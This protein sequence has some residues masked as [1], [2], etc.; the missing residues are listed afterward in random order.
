MAK[1]AYS[2]FFGFLLGM[3]ILQGPLLAQ[4]KDTLSD[5]SLMANNKEEVSLKDF[6]SS[7]AVVIVFTSS[8]CK[9]AT[10]YEERLSELNETY[11]EK[12]ISFIAINSNDP[13]L[14]DS[15][16]ETQMAR[17]SHYSFPYLKD[18]DQSVAKQF[19][20]VKTPE[21]IVATPKDGGFHEAYRGK[22]DDN[23]LDASLAKNHYLE[24]ALKQILADEAVT[25]T[26]TDASGCNIKWIR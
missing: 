24:D 9:W 1:L 13:S 26:T 25:V 10:M 15:D 11:S 5:F 17:L 22:I 6:D 20:A 14:S 21:V 4:E 18:E 2:T 19:K 16:S 7:K 3:L 12:G 23:P 8:H